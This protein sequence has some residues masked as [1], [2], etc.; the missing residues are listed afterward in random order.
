MGNLYVD[1]VCWQIGIHPASVMGA[2]S[3]EKRRALFQRMQAILQKAVDLDA[4]YSAYPEEWLWNHR[5]ND[6]GECPRDGS[7][8]EKDKVAGRTTYYCPAC[9]ELI[10]EE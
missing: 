10:L 7:S 3:A 9:Q 4:E 5:H 2:L 6:H 8:L 1:E